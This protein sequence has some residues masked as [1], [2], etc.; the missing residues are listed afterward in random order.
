[1]K[2]RLD[3]PLPLHCSGR[4]PPRFAFLIVVVEAVQS[5]CLT[6]DGMVVLLVCMLL[7]SL[8]L[9]NDFRLTFMGGVAF[10]RTVFCV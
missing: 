10:A 8:P 1:M 7:A 5:C 9:E 6:Q 2:R 4:R 3:L